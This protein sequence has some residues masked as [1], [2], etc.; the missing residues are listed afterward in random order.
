MV[1]RN[2]LG[3]EPNFARSSKTPGGYVGQA[4]LVRTF[5]NTRSSSLRVVAEQCV[6]QAA[7]SVPQFHQP[8]P[9]EDPTRPKPLGKDTR[10]VIR[11]SRSLPHLPAA[12]ALTRI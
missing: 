5:G 4:A 8:P 6:K 9:C 12:C 3:G 1:G 10:W 7:P 2:Q 11:G